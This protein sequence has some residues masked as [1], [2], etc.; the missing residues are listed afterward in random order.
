MKLFLSDKD[1]QKAALEYAFETEEFKGKALEFAFNQQSKPKGFSD[2]KQVFIDSNGKRYYQY[3][4]DM[5]IPIK[6]LQELDR[7]R[8]EM[9]SKLSNKELKTFLNVMSEELNNAVNTT[10]NKVTNIAKIGFLIEEMKSR[11]TILF[12]ADLQFEL[13]A[14]VLIREDENPAEF[15]LDIHRQ[16]VEQFKKDSEGGLRDFFYNAGLKQYLPFL[17]LSTEDYNQYLVESKA[18]IAAQTKMLEQF[19]SEAKSSQN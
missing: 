11:D 7:V 12:H 9:D 6:R 1:F 2:T 13:A 10:K 8:M 17:E 18:K 19:I 3:L 4:D 16:K 15:D 5:N 14:I